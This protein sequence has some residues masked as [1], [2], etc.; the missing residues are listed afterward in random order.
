M[1]THCPV[2]KME[3][4]SR[5]KKPEPDGPL[6]AVHSTAGSDSAFEIGP[7]QA[8]HFEEAVTN[9]F[10]L[11]RPGKYTIRAAHEFGNFLVKANSITIVATP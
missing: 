11:T 2:K 7:R 3:A 4:V 6:N 8:L 5:E 1:A 10:D 9:K